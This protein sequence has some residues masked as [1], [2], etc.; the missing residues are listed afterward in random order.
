MTTY[1][2]KL[3][4]NSLVYEEFLD[5]MLKEHV[6]E[7]LQN[8]GFTEAELLLE[9][10]EPEQD[11]S[12]I[13]VLYRVKSRGD[14]DQYL[15]DSAPR[16]RQKSLDRWGSH[17][18]AEREIWDLS[19]KILQRDLH[20][21]K[22]LRYIEWIKEAQMAYQLDV[23][24]LI[25]DLRGPKGVSALTEEIAKVSGEIQKL[26]QTLQPQ[27]E[28]KIKQARITLDHV[29][30]RLKAAQNDLDKE[31]DRTLVLVKKYGKEAEKGFQ[32]IKVAVTKKKAGKPPRKATKKA[33]TKKKA[34]SQ[35][36]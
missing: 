10:Y 1:I 18:S 17:F 34:S 13:Y 33:S 20:E 8:P 32:K 14:L 25:K 23:K 9:K 22:K 6:F 2:V 27:A 26:R 19:K 31:L 15:K 5:W 16:L 35:K 29:Q 24:K 12:H 30:K 7:V 28:A 4:V 3:T 36:A 21:K 11:K